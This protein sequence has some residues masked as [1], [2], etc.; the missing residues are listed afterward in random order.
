LSPRGEI[1]S[2]F[3]ARVLEVDFLAVVLFFAIDVPPAELLATLS[4]GMAR[5][6]SYSMQKRDRAPS[7]H[8]SVRN[9]IEYRRVETAG[10]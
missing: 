7:N 5:Q 9:V 8:L 6:V 1:S 10:M 2:R 4:P 3:A